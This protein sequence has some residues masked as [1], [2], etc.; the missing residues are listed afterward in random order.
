MMTPMMMMLMM[1]MMMS[2]RC[3]KAHFPIAQTASHKN[4]ATL[5]P[6]LGN[7]NLGSKNNTHF[8]S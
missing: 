5:M 3:H 2:S 7:A 8:T 1:M 4:L 6:H